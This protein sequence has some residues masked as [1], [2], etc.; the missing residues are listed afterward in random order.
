[1]H[2]RSCQI[3]LKYDAILIRVLYSVFFLDRL[4]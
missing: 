3:A 2:A 1:V 4:F